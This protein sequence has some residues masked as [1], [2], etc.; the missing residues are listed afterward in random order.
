VGF[1]RIGR[2]VGEI[3]AA[4]GMLVVA[5]DE[6]QKI[7]PTGQASVGA[8]SMNLMSA[9]DVVSLHC[10]LL[11][12]TRGMMNAETLSR[13]KP[14]SI[15]INTWRG[16]LVVEQHLA[17]ALND[18]HLAGGVDVL[19]SEPPPLDNPLLHAKNCIITPHIAWATK[20]ACMRLIESAAANLRAF[21]EGLPVNVVN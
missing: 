12:S 21:L 8:M 19:S 20:E 10:P 11:P 3:A 1:G 6:S 14:G 5:A 2:H 16:T 15:L 7:C 18:G 4:V 13:M 9:S 17:N